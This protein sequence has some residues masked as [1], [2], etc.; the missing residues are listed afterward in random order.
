MSRWSS[1]ESAG[2]RHRGRAICP[3]GLV[4]RATPHVIWQRVSDFPSLQ[5]EPWKA[6]FPMQSLQ[7]RHDRVWCRVDLVFADHASG[8]LAVVDTVDFRLFRRHER[9]PPGAH[10]VVDLKLEQH[11]GAASGISAV[12]HLE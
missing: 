11:G 9:L 3:F 1:P 12:E 10:A 7:K 4:V 6:P 5:G 2:Q 8:E